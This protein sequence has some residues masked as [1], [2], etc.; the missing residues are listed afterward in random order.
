MRILK[1]LS[2]LL[3]IV[4]LAS[5]SF[6]EENAIPHKYQLNG[7]KD[8]YDLSERDAE[9]AGRALAQKDFE[10][11]IYRILVYG[12]RR[13]EDPSEKRL[14]DEFQVYTIAC[15]GCIVS[16]GIL[17]FTKGYNDTMKSLLIKH[18]KKDIFVGYSN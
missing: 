5:P 16:D 3:L 7:Y 11:G 17:G 13:S 18:F 10:S 4:I 12:L 2:F 15:A 1:S 9:K 14:K 6:A 8:Y